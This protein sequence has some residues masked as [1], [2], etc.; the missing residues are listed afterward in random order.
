MSQPQILGSCSAAR[1]MDMFAWPLCLHKIFYGSTNVTSLSTEHCGEDNVGKERKNGYTIIFSKVALLQTF[2]WVVP[3]WPVLWTSVELQFWVSMSNS[4][5]TGCLAFWK[6]PRRQV[7]I[8]TREQ[9]CHSPIPL[10]LLLF[11]GP[12]NLIET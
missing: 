12:I 2:Y 11:A 9:Q 4:C 8:W 6:N 1:S 10:A 3:M 5:R 7:I